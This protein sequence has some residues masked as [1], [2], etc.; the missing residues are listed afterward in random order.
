MATA[1]K[2]KNGKGEG[3]KDGKDGQGG[4]LRL[5][6]E[7]TI[8]RAGELKA[9]LQAALEAAGAAL[10][11]DLSGVTELDT[12]GIQLL[13][14]AKREA[15]AKSCQLRLSGHSAAVLEAFE[16]LNLAPYFGDPLVM[17]SAARG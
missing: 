8:Y 15:Q 11:L 6:G 12:A 9:R 16:L 1:R 2:R 4:G 5:D 10:E 13:M 3:G 17:A 7:W 14:Q